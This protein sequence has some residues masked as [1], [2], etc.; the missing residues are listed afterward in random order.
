MKEY[1]ALAVAGVFVV[2]IMDSNSWDRE[3]P[4]FDSF[5]SLTNIKH[6]EHA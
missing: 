1:G 5:I 2:F 3:I 6:L 4:V